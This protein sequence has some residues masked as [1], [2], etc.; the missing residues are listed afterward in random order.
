MAVALDNLSERV[1]R[2]HA[3]LRELERFGIT[4]GLDRIGALLEGLG[5]PQAGARGVLIAGTNGKGSVAAMTEAC[6]RAAGL[7]TVMFTSPH[8]IRWNERYRID[9]CPMSDVDLAELL[10]TVLAVSI[11]SHLGPATQFEVLTA[12]AALAVGRWQPDVTI[13]EVGLGGRL[14]CTNVFD[15]GV[16]A[17]T[18]IGLDHTDIL[19]PDVRGIAAE[20]AGIVKAGNDVVVGNAGD[21]LDVIRDTAA[22]A[23]ARGVRILGEDLT[24]AASESVDGIVA[25][26]TSSGR[27]LS[28][29]TPLSGVHQVAN[30]AVAVG[31]CDA[32]VAGG[33][34]LPDEAI[35]AG[36]STV[37]WPGRME[38]LSS[39]LLVD[40]AH[41]PAAT[42]AL[43][44]TVLRLPQ[45][46][47]PRA[48]VVGIMA[49]KDIPEIL[50]ILASLSIPVVVTAA[51][52]PRAASPSHLAARWPGSEPAIPA[53]TV[54]DALRIAQR[55]TDGPT[56]VCGSLAVVGEVLA[57]HRSRDRPT[58]GS[59]C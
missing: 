47:R 3:R 16:A 43:V 36:L 4:P 44:E 37:S 9:G 29:S 56:L 30:A 25:R 19:G 34:P 32:I 8:L 28:V 59:P 42:E 33:T 35:V 15:L 20:K 10:D 48:A 5:A 51:R 1:A 57:L 46:R 13:I 52:T 21:T 40:A 24:V 22:A 53:A 6:A 49:D 54:P 17:I 50:R 23:G 26:V 39:D 38:W 31:V 14:D 11:P 12:M 2:T 41:N 55:L 7:H 18:S 45:H 27:T 58:V